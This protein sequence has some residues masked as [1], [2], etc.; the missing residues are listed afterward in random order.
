MP[1]RLARISGFDCG[2]RNLNGE[3]E[4]TPRS[5]ING[6]F[7]IQLPDPFPYAQQSE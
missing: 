7:A 1:P 6:Q 2:H 5:A 3:P 4:T